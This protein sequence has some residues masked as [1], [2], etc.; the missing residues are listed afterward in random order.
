MQKSEKSDDFL[1]NVGEGFGSGFRLRLESEEGDDLGRRFG[2]G[3][4]HFAIVH[5]LV[6]G[7][8]EIEVEGQIFGGGVEDD[9]DGSAGDLVF[10]ANVGDDFGFHF[11]GI[12]VS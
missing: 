10:A 2:E 4:S 5:L 9:A 6:G 3:E 8:Q 11:D 1:K 12:G 7:H